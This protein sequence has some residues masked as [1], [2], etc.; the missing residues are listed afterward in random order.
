MA[1]GFSI[2]YLARHYQVFP[3]KRF[4]ERHFGEAEIPVAIYRETAGRVEVPCAESPDTQVIFIFGQS[5]SANHVGMRHANN[6]I[7][8]SNYFQG[9]CYV[10]QDPLLGATGWGGG[11]GIPLAN[12]LLRREFAKRIIL[13][14]L[15]VGE[16]TVGKWADE[17]NLG[18]RLNNALR[19]LKDLNI[20]VGWY[21]YIQGESDTNT[22]ISTYR[23]SLE[24]IAGFIRAQYPTAKLGISNTSY[25]FGQSNPAVIKAQNEFIAANSPFAFSLGNT[26]NFNSDRDRYDDCHFSELAIPDLV[27]MMADNIIKQAGH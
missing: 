2:G 26:D 8:I 19:E 12:E 22:D 17:K 13:V 9:K 20:R 4:F 3:L 27:R 15:G 6:S 7:T 23:N 14:P 21:L 10:A 5:N 25:C 24:K 1:I 11:I 18:R 16:A